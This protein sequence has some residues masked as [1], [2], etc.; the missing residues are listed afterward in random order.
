VT[1][2]SQQ[3]ELEAVAREAIELGYLA[4][5]DFFVWGV[6][7]DLS[8]EVVALGPEGDDLVVWYRDRGRNLEI[9]R[10]QTVIGV[11]DVF[12]AE[13]ARLAGP[14]GRGPYAGGRP[15]GRY[16]GMTPERALDRL[17]SQG[18]F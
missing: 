15:P 2:V 10:S 16:D 7:A 6:R 4:G 12:F 11:H 5:T 14:R 9:A 18:Y 17:T 1:D 8:S 13:L 3:E